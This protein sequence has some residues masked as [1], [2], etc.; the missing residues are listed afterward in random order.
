M[1]IEIPEFKTRADMLSYMRKNCEKII[2]QKKSL[3]IKSD[4]LEFGY[5]IVK[6]T[7]QL[8]TKAAT[9][10]ELAMPVDGELPVEIIGNMSGWCDS[11]MDVMVKDNWN[12]SINDLGASGQKLVYHLKNHDYSTD[13]VVGKDPSLYTKDIDLSIFNFKSD[14]KK[15][16]ALLMSSTV[17]KAYDEKCYMLYKD[18]QVK[19]HSIGL[20]YIK[21]YLCID[22]DEAEDTMYKENWDK[23]YSQVINKEKVDS[24]GYFWAVTEAQILEVSVVLFGAN[25][26]TTVQSIGKN[27]THTESE[28]PKDTQ[29]QP[30]DVKETIAEPVGVDWDKLA[31]KF[32]CN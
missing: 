8:G 29:E 30:L 10:E 32:L 20:R 14:I 28:P 9:P 31:N 12:K 15:A 7:R 13:A 26:L 2:A 22:S 21:L 5:S 24:K 25:E 18:G 16:Q 17:V 1:R 27:E 11:Y 3:P 4:N 6:H 19:Q 23:Y